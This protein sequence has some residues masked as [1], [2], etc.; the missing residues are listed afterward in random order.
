MPEHLGMEFLGS[1]IEQHP[2]FS[3]VSH[4]SPAVLT[5]V[6]PAEAPNT[7]LFWVSQGREYKSQQSSLHPKKI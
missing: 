6:L 7:A 2:N 4:A 3:T 5:P 1:V